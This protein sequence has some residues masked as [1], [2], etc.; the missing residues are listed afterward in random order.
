[1]PIIG[2]PLLARIRLQQEVKSICKSGVEKVR[3]R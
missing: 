2:N 3:A 1:M